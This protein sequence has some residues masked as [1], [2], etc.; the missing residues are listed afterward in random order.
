MF[1]KKIYFIYNFNYNN[2]IKKNDSKIEQLIKMLGFVLEM[3]I[4]I[5]Q[6]IFLRIQ[7]YSLLVRNIYVI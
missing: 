4:F 2:N 6:I 1:Q 3:Y 5:M 7:E